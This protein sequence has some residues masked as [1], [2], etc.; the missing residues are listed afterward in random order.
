MYGTTKNIRAVGDNF[1][2]PIPSEDTQAG[3]ST[4][5]QDDSVAGDNINTQS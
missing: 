4:T 2:C 1:T 3:E 5:T